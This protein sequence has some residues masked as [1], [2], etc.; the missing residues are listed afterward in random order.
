MF[1]KLLVFGPSVF[2]VQSWGI[3]IEATDSVGL[4]FKKTRL[5]QKFFL[6]SET[7]VSPKHEAMRTY[8]VSRSLRQKSSCF[9]QPD[10]SLIFSLRFPVHSTHP[11]LGGRPCRGSSARL[12]GGA[13]RRSSEWSSL[14]VVDLN[15][16]IKYDIHGSMMVWNI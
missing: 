8:I 14:G 7:F 10:G 11:G 6:L 9:A 12:C 2:G 15:V 1:G 3:V 16:G 13:S 5:N 4:S